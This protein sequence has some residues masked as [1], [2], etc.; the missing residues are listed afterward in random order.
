MRLDY[1][2]FLFQSHHFIPDGGGGNIQ[3]IIVQQALRRHRCG[4][5]NVLLNNGF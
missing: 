1:V 5:R 3:A 4:P 2:T